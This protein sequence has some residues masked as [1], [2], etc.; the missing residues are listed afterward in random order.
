MDKTM[1]L[2]AEQP[3]QSLQAVFLLMPCGV[4]ACSDWKDIRAMLHGLPPKYGGEA[5]ITFCPPEASLCDRDS[6]VNDVISLKKIRLG[7]NC[8]QC[9]QWPAKS[10]RLLALLPHFVS[11]NPSLQRSPH[12][13]APATPEGSNASL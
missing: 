11:R 7:Q 6:Q 2:P 1:V 10:G 3:C 8:A 12:C 13:S 9:A 5:N 4:T